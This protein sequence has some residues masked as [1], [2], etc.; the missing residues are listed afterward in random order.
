LIGILLLCKNEAQAIPFICEQLN[1]YRDNNEF[2]ILFVDGNSE[3]GSKELISKLGF[4][5]I[6]QSKSGMRTA[7]NEGVLKL[8]S[9]NVKHIVF[10]QPDGNCDISLMKT[11]IQPL[12]SE[13]FDMVIASRYLDDS[14]SFD[15]TFVSALGN[16]LFTKLISFLSKFAYTDAMV[17]YRGIKVEVIINLNILSNSKFKIFEKLFFTSLGWDPLLSTICPLCGYKVKE[18]AISEPPRLG[19]VVKK[20]TIR[21][22]LA[23]FSQV[24]VWGAIIRFSPK[25]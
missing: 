20:Q 18:V 2:Y 10:A 11:V 9:K 12:I 23:Y 16:R 6:S 5:V 8:L 1:E 3:D 13:D 15:D 14:E 21:W 4:N 22:G 17:G 7:I 19:G 24:I 25:L